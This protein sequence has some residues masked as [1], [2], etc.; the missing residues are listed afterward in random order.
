MYPGNGK[1]RVY[2]RPSLARLLLVLE[3]CRDALNEL[4]PMI[5][6]PDRWVSLVHDA[7]VAG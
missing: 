1:R 5:A 6:A 2:S 7:C 3:P 4:V